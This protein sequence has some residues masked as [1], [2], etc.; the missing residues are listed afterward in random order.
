MPPVEY[1][2][3]FI[4]DI[5]TIELNW[6]NA[7]NSVLKTVSIILLIVFVIFTVIGLWFHLIQLIVGGFVSLIAFNVL[8]NKIGKI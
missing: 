8:M 3:S 6:L 7:C 5:V 4:Q 1:T 2:Y